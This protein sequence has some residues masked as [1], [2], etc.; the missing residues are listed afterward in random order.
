MASRFSIW[1]WLAVLLIVL[2]MSGGLV[3]KRRRLQLRRESIWPV[4]AGITGLLLAWLIF[5]QLGE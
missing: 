1:Q 5:A 2:G 4:T 3:A